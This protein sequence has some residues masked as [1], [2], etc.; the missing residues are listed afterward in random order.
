MGSRLEPMKRIA[1]SLRAHEELIVNWFRA[2]GQYSAGVVEGLN[3]N[4]KLGFRK[5]Y[6]F[7][8]YEAAEVAL[9]HR[10]G[11]LPEPDIAHR[12]C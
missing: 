1:R 7:R 4:V 10:L 2:K 12:F 11:R 5:A 9:Y 8:T 3:A 6:G